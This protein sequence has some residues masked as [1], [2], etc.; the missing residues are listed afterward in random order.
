MSGALIDEALPGF[1]EIWP[2]IAEDS[3]NTATR[4]Q[5]ELY[6]TFE[7]LAAMSDESSGNDYNDPQMKMGCA[8][9]GTPLMDSLARIYFGKTTPSY[10]RH[11]SSAS[12]GHD[13]PKRGR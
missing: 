4:I 2:Y 11:S 9:N 13:H 10:S 7:S 5:F 6:A 8:A 12:D 3:E 1:L